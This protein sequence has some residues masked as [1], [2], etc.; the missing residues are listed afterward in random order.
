MRTLIVDDDVVSRR[1]LLEILK[2]YGECQQAG[3]GREALAAFTGALDKNP[4][5][6]VLLDIQMPDIDGQETLAAIRAIEARRGVPPQ[7]GVKVIMATVNADKTSIFTAFRNQ[8][9]AYMIKP[10]TSEGVM[11]NLEQFGLVPW[12]RGGGSAPQN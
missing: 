1:V 9:E 5:D 11:V 7:L 3:T 2:P 12:S 8:C 4:F 10:V 6:L